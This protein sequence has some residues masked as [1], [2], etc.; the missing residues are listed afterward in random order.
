[1]TILVTGATG[2]VGHAVVDALVAAGQDVRASSRDAA[3]LDVPD[4][5]AKVNADLEDPSTLE[6]AR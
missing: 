6:P 4:G 1:M 3:K 5:V 2:H